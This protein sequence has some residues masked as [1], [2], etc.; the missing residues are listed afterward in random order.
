LFRGLVFAL[1]A[2]G[3]GPF[4]TGVYGGQ[5]RKVGIVAQILCLHGD[6]QWLMVGD[7]HID[8]QGAGYGY[9]ATE[10]YPF[11]D[12]VIHRLSELLHMINP[13]RPVQ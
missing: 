3:I 6:P 10:N 11:F 5:S 1:E 2:A 13:R 7:M 4:F 12:K 9:Y 8:A